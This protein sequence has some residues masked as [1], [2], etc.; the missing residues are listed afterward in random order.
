MKILTKLKI[1]EHELPV[2]Q[3]IPKLYFDI[4]FSLID[5]VLEIYVFFSSLHLNSER[6]L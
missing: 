2:G 1:E 6:Q 5:I 3:Y 4:K